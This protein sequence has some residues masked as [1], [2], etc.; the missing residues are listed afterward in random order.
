M[1][2]ILRHETLLRHL[3]TKFHV[4]LDD[5]NTVEIELVKVGDRNVS[6]Q[7]ERFSIF[8]EGPLVPALTQGTY[9]FTHEAMGTFLLFIVPIEHDGNGIRYE[10]V[11]NRLTKPTS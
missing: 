7:Q 9:S 1:D 5:S 2:D 3:N 6:P 8:F 4:S 11:F 10:A